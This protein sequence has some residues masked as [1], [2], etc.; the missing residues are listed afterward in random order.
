MGDDSAVH[1]ASEEGRASAEGAESGV[2]GDDCSVS[3]DGEAVPAEWRLGLGRRRTSLSP[4]VILSGR[5]S[6]CSSRR[7][8]GP[9]SRATSTAAWG[10]QQHGLT[11]LY[12]PTDPGRS[13]TDS[14]VKHTL[15]LC[16]P[17]IAR[18][19]IRT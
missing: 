16:P 7:R 2:G 1:E 9:I 15:D 18:Q 4:S 14:T 6:S 19:P 13:G 17:L 5:E 3:G 11:L 12:P 8:C 10:V